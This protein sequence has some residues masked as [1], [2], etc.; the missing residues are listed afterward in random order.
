MVYARD[1]CGGE[2][3]LERL[4]YVHHGDPGLVGQ[5][6]LEAK[7]AIRFGT[8][9]SGLIELERN[10]ARHPV[11]PQEVVIKVTSVKYSAL[12]EITQA[13]IREDQVPCI[14]GHAGLETVLLLSPRS[15]GRVTGGLSDLRGKLRFGLAR[16]GWDL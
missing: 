15:L 4:T 5:L 12:P 7:G 14:L 6:I 1:A 13:E 9:G 2:V 8:E 11:V 16:I 10:A 3:R